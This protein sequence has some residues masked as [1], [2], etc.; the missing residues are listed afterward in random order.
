MRRFILSTLALVALAAPA[1]A[2]ER[3]CR[4]PHQMAVDFTQR[5]QGKRPPSP[6]RGELPRMGDPSL[7]RPTFDQTV[8]ADAMKIFDRAFKEHCKAGDVISLVPAF[9]SFA[10]THC[11][12]NRPTHHVGNTVICF[13]QVPPRE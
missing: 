4:E 1:A 2:Q 12:L 3:V 8:R 6:T 9:Q 5:Q 11:D 7:S 10:K 13:A